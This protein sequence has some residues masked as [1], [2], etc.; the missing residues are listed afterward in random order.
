MD[1]LAFLYEFGCPTPVIMISAAGDAALNET[2]RIGKFLDD[3][4]DAAIPK[5]LDLGLLRQT[6][7]QVP[8]EELATSASRQAARRGRRSLRPRRKPANFGF[9]MPDHDPTLLYR[10]TISSLC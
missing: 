3:N 7:A 10:I 2:V 6:R 9:A 4:L 5:P 8:S 1:V